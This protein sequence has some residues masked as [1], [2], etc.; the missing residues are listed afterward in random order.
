MYERVIP[1]DLF[2]EAKLLKCLGQLCLLIH[3]EKAGPFISFEH[4]TAIAEGFHI[5]QDP[6]DGG[7]F[8]ANLKFFFNQ[9]ELTLKTNLNA[10]DPYPLLATVLDS[11]EFHVFNDDGSLSD[12]FKEMIHA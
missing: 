10:R 1:R 12:E 6:N 4:D 2:N 9:W 7:L 5:D 3:D 11:E 8:C